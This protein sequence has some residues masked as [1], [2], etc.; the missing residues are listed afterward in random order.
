MSWANPTI[1]KKPKGIPKPN[2]V[3]FFLLRVQ[4]T[5]FSPFIKLSIDT[6]KVYKQS[7]HKEYANLVGRP[8]FHKGFYL[9][10]SSQFSKICKEFYSI[11]ESVS[12]SA[13]ANFVKFSVDGEV[14]SGSVK[15]G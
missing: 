7:R 12:V 9:H 5:F 15:L 2:P 1:Q 11:S 10:I 3:T 14:S 8:I 4:Y 13:T 6:F